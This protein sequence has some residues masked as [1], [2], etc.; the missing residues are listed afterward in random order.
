MFTTDDPFDPDDIGFDADDPTGPVAQLG[1]KITWT[2]K[3]TNTG[4]VPLDITSVFDDNETALLPP[5]SGGDDFE[6]APVLKDNGFNFGAVTSGNFQA[7]IVGSTAAMNAAENALV[8][9]S[10]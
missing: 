3:V 1:N 8:N 9:F 4:S 7:A 6:P 10:F 2:Y 5:G